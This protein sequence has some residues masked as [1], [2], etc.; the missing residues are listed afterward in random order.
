MSLTIAPPTTAAAAAI[1]DDQWNE[2]CLA[3][4]GW[5]ITRTDKAW[6]VAR[7][8]WAVQV[9]QQPAAVLEVADQTDVALAVRWAARHGISVSAQP[10]GH[11]AR[12]T[13]DGT[14][15]LRTGALQDI[16]IDVVRRTAR[17]GAGVRWGDLLARLDGTGLIALA[18]SNPDPTVVGL[19]LGGGVSWFTRKYGYAANS[20][21]SFDVVDARGELRHVTAGSD[22]ELFWALRG[23]GG[24]FAVV[25]AVEIELHP[26]A[27]LYGGRLFWD[28]TH[29]RAVLGAFRDLT[30]EAPVE[31]TTWAH[32]YHFP[33]VPDVPEPVRGRSFVSVAATYLGSP[34][35]AEQLLA[36]LRSA[37]PVAL[38][39]MGELQIGA[40][41]G[42]AD[43]PTEPMPVMDHTALLADLTDAGLDAF[44]AAVSDRA[45]C[46]L[47]LVQL[48]H[49]EG[50]FADQPVDGGAVSPVDARFSLFA[51]GVPVVPELAGAIEAGFAAL[52]DSL[53]DV[54]QARR[55][56]NFTGE[57]QA[58]SA[59]YEPATLDR[60]RRLKLERDPAGTIR[61]NKPVLDA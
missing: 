50:A 53:A 29:T 6:D 5:P 20:V 60:L 36:P 32:V 11:A 18:G 45:T 23:G 28:V 4:S 14:L 55:F 26:E 7:R 54:V 15:L 34:G 57:G 27:E 8:G 49:L 12:T 40:L 56:P 51:L 35:K 13:L 31:L 22:P 38:D 61:S 2:L 33:P 42:V 10:R 44:T 25:V 3:V 1:T 30:A 59:G 46:P 58:N 43:E 41:A 39:L 47:A 19:T 17:V 48:R 21:R 16:D 9:D 24:D 37:A 52:D